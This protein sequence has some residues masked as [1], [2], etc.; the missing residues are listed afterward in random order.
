MR[1]GDTSPLGKRVTAGE[2]TIGNSLAAHDALDATATAD[3]TPEAGTALPHIAA[4]ERVCE[5]C[6]K[7][8]LVRPHRILNAQ[9]S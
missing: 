5:S 3:G 8:R 6:A 7:M 4:G 1:V 9:A 2:T